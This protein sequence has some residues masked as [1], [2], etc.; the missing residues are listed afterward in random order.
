[1]LIG[2]NAPAFSQ[3]VLESDD[4]DATLTGTWTLMTAAPGYYGTGYRVAVGGGTS[5]IAKF[6]SANPISS[7]GSWCVEARWTADTDRSTAVQYKIYDNNTVRKTVTVD[8]T[9][10]GGV[11]H[12]L[13][14][15]RFTAGKNSTVSVSDIGAG[16][17]KVIVADGV[18]W[19]WDETTNIGN[20]PQDYCIA[21]K[22][23]WDPNNPGG[24]TFIA[25]NFVY[26]P[27]GACRSWTGIV[28]LSISVVGTTIGAA[29]LSDDGQRF[30][31]AL[32]SSLPNWAGAGFVHDNIDLCPTGTCP[33]ASGGGTITERD[34]GFI[35]GGPTSNPAARVT[36]TVAMTPVPSAH[37]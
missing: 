16:S 35:L 37:D 25:K 2:S 30:T 5:D 34:F 4:N 31:A 13:G 33:P 28:R 20:N 19:V 36:C 11:W 3:V 10:K 17:G 14:C 32:M 26:P 29:C 27:R 23:G 9:Q 18:R 24:A 8:Q 12:P 15:V 7:S 1:L 22:G 6:K 21:V